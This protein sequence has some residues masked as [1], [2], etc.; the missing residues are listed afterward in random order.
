MEFIMNIDKRK[1][2]AEIVYQGYGGL[3][4]GEKKEYE[5]EVG[6]AIKGYTTAMRDIAQ[7]LV[8]GDCGLWGTDS[9]IGV[10]KNYILSQMNGKMK[11]GNI[12]RFAEMPSTTMLGYIQTTVKAELIRHRCNKD[13]AEDIIKV[14]IENPTE[15]QDI[16]DEWELETIRICEHCGRLMYEGYL[17][18]DCE[19]FCSK[20]CVKEDKGWSEAEFN[21]EIANADSDN[22]TIYWTKWEG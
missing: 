21:E 4:D 15:R 2:L 7:I 10:L 11:A 16:I 3:E 14:F 17:V 13:D 22:A 19:C 5:N 18:D 8:N 6:A 12:F 9:T 20:D 1:E